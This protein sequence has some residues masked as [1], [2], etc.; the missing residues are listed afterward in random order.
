MNG[1]MEEMILV[2]EGGFCSYIVQVN[3][4]IL[5]ERATM[6]GIMHF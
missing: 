5:A 6:C 1:N 3:T 2:S 4:R